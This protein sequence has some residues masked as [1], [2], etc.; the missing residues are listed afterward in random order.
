MDHP[1]DAATFVEQYDGG[2]FDG[3]LHEELVNLSQEQLMEIAALLMARAKEKKK[4]AYL[5]RT[6]PG[7][8]AGDESGG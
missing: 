8:G 7:G 1:F 3:R 6:Q 5:G 2:A 4:S